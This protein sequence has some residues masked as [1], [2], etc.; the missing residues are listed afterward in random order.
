MDGNKNKKH[1]RKSK[2]KLNSNELKQNKINP[3]QPQKGYE[4]NKN[5]KEN[6]FNTVY[7]TKIDNNKGYSYKIRIS[8]YYEKKLMQ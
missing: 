8:P 1:N 3:P 6:T 4:S 2:I 5:L 7:I